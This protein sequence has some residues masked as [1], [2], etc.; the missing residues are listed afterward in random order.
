MSDSYTRGYWDRI[1]KELGGTDREDLWR[2]HLKEVYQ[3]L[4]DRWMQ[5]SP[6]GRALKTDLFDEA[7]GTDGLIPLCGQKCDSVFGTD[8][9]FEVAVA[10]KRRMIKERNGW[11]GP[12]CSDVRKLPFKSESFDH[13]ISNST[14]DHFAHKESIRE[15]LRELCRLMRSG[16]SLLITLDNPSNPIVL[17]RNLAPYRLLK[18]L[19]IIPF[20]MG[21][22]LS[23]SQL[24]RMLESSG[25]EVDEST[26][27]VHSPRIL[28][29]WTGRILNR[30]G[31]RKVKQY[32]SRVLEVCERLEKLP[33][34]Y[35]SG[36]YVAALATKR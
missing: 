15:S 13:V 24:I 32:V 28:A 9:S 26:A 25:F 30:T 34:R 21:V 8:V 11:H 3:E 29:I 4:M 5:S 20:Y 31:N 17:F 36:Y 2:G 6:G 27:I 12:I 33:T 10:A 14:L 23:K 7:I 35:L 1:I 22:T 19:G 16:G 18:L